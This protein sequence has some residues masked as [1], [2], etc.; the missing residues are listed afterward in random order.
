ML[1][2]GAITNILCNDLSFSFTSLDQWKGL[3]NP[4]QDLHFDI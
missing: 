3:V 2:D 1:V 4:P